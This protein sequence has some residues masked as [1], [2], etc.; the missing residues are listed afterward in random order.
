MFSERGFDQEAGLVSWEELK[1][2]YTVRQDLMKD[3]GMKNLTHKS[4]KYAGLFGT[5]DNKN[6]NHFIIVNTLVL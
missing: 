5:I 6:Q 1:P 3:V 2:T 4:V